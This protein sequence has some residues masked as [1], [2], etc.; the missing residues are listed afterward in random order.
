MIEFLNWW[1]ETWPRTMT[2]LFLLIGIGELLHE[3]INA[4]IVWAARRH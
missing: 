4:I 2:G 3:L 1:V